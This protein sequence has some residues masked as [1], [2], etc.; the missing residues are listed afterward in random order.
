MKIHQGLPRP[1][2]SSIFNITTPFPDPALP[3]LVEDA[4]E[5]DAEVLLPSKLQPPSQC[6]LC[7]HPF[8]TLP[9]KSGKMTLNK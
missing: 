8:V 6:L 1:L 4:L 5:D 7:L 2:P 3:D 9:S